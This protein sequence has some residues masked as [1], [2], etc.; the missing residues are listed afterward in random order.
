[1]TGWPELVV[2][3][4]EVGLFW[5]KYLRI[6]RIIKVAV[7]PRTMRAS[8]IKMAVIQGLELVEGGR[9]LA[10][11]TGKGEGLGLVRAGSLEASGEGLPAAS[12]LMR[13][14]GVGEVEITT[15]TGEGLGVG[16]VA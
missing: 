12:G 13:G 6:K 3:A 14:E 15:S 2:A 5:P 9:V 1:M 16:R 10:I 8:A 11:Q 7:K 4:G